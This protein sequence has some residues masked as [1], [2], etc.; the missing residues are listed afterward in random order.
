MRRAEMLL[1]KEVY[2]CDGAAQVE[3]AKVAKGAY[4]FAGGANVNAWTAVPPAAA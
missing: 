2:G 3:A 1:Q 4:L